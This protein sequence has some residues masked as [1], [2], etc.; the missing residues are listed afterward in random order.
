MPA[1]DCFRAAPLKIQAWLTKVVFRR[2]ELENWLQKLRT[3]AGSQTETQYLDWAAGQFAAFMEAERSRLL[4][5]DALAQAGI[6]AGPLFPA[7]IG[8]LPQL[9][10]ASGPG[11]GG[12]RCSAAIVAGGYSICRAG[13]PPRRTPVPERRLASA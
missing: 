2:P 1:A 11:L 6:A 8:D 3:G 5:E 4:P 13:Q 7:P 10:G 9:R 12:S